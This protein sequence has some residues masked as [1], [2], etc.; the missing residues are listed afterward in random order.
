MDLPLFYYSNE[1]FFIN[2]NAG[3]TKEKKLKV[4][5]AL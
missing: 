1:I 3:R 4:E 2:S 5:R